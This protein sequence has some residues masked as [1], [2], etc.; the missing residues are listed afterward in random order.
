[1]AT[2]SSCHEAGK[3]QLVQRVLMAALVVIC[4]SSDAFLAQ[5]YVPLPPLY[6]I[7]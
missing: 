4:V 2:L 3:A 1:M 7:K 5:E 6:I